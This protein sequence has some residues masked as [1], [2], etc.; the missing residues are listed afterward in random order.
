MIKYPSLELTVKEALKWGKKS[1]NPVA[2]PGKKHHYT[3][4]N[5]LHAGPD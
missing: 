5:L 3:D 2:V 1:L 4:T